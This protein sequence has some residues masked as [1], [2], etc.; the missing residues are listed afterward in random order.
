QSKNMFS[1]KPFTL[2]LLLLLLF[3]GLQAQEDLKVLQS[4]W[5]HFSDAPNAL[6]KHL[7]GEAFDMLEERKIKVKGINSLRE[8]KSRQQFI[9]KQLSEVLGPF[10]EKNPLNAQIIRTVE[11]DDYKVE[12]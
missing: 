7:T 10:P 3:Q 4:R 1:Y 11:K 12:H 6:Y 9:E 5:V 2:T 8:W